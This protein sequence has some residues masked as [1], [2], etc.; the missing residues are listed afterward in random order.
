MSDK[1]HRVIVTGGRN[2]QDYKAVWRA[3]DFLREQYGIFTVVQ[4]GANGADKFARHWADALRHPSETF[5]ANWGEHGRAAGPIRNQAMLD[6][7]ANLVVAFK[8]GRGT[9]NMVGIARAAGIEVWEAD[10]NPRGQTD[11]T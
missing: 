8:G 5:A 10:K 9:A 6:A 3:L 2:Y 4:G 7:G 1:N 11:E